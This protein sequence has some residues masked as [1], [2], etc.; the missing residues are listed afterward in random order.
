MKI[1]ISIIVS[2]ALLLSAFAQASKMPS[3]EQLSNTAALLIDDLVN[4]EELMWYRSEVFTG[5]HYAEAVTVYGALQVAA[6]LKDQNR[7]KALQTKYRVIPD[8]DTLASYHHVDGNVIGIVPFELYKTIGDEE[9]KQQGLWLADTQWENPWDNGMTSQ[10]RY[11]IDDIYMINAIQMQAYRL[12]GKQE[13]LDRAALNTR[14]YLVKIQQEN[15][16]FWHGPNAP[17]F[18]GRGNGWVVAGVAELLRELPQDHQ[19]Y[20]EITRRYQEMMKTLL[21]HQADSG[22][23]RQLVT[24][25]ESWE[26]SSATAMFAWSM[27]VG[28]KQGILEEDEYLPAVLSAWNGLLQQL[29][30]DGKLKEICVGTG[31]SKDIQYYLDRPRVTGDLHGQAP[32]LWLIGALLD[33]K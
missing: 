27:L 11:W 20:A 24:N 21:S 8:F 2:F 32:M 6:Q 22:M 30:E 16:L 31:Q 28:V 4:R 29:G 19:D 12:T 26:E 9:L 25:P 10:S 13:Y 5:F 33:L 15:G 23:W 17:H 1:M 14:A 18:W 3:D 7:L